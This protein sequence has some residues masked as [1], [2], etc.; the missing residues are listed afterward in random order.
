[1]SITKLTVAI[2]TYD[3]EA[4]LRQ[5][6]E[7]LQ[8]QTEQ[9]FKVILFDNASPY[10]VETLIAEFPSLTITLKSNPTNIGNQANFERVMTYEFDTPY[11]MVFHDDDTI[12]P[13]YFEDALSVLDANNKVRWVGSF[14][15]YVRSAARM[16]EFETRPQAVPMHQYTRRQLADI[17]MSSLPVGFSPVVYRASVLADT[18]IHTSHFY[19]WFDRPFMLDTING[20]QA[21]IFHFPYINYRIHPSQDSAQEYN[22]YIPAIINL[23]H[24]ISSAGSP[25][26]GRKYSTTNALRTAI[27]NASSIKEFTSILKKFEKHNLYR[28]IDIRPYSIYWLLRILLKRISGAILSKNLQ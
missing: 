6:L 1:M 15:K 19:K 20:G 25:S 24:Y 18:K 14:I 9:S 3:R 11:V 21:A 5:T 17:F 28:A 23:T 13:N 12:H 22:E 2:P 27:Q 16:L 10:D 4:Y 7:S 26:I 8:N